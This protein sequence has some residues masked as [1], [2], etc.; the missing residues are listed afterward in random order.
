M[1]E[2]TSAR[3]W[4]SIAK[5]LYLCIIEHMTYFY[6]MRKRAGIHEVVHTVINKGNEKESQRVKRTNIC[7]PLSTRELPDG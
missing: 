6:Y 7:M 1:G 4:N 3:L 2:K 5:L